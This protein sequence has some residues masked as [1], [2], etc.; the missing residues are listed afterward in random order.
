[1]ALV[2]GNGS[3]KS[4]ALSVLCGLQRPV[5]GRIK[6]AKGSRVALLVQRPR[7]LFTCDT[8]REDLDVYKRQIL[9][10]SLP[11]WILT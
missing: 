6:R 1:M 2:G 11:R 5:R 7:A 4:T 10:R 8:L 3:G 9:R